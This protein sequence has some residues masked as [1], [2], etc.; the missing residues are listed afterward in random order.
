MAKKPGIFRRVFNW[1]ADADSA[2]SIGDWIWRSVLLLVPAVNTFWASTRSFQGPQLVWIFLFTVAGVLAVPALGVWLGV[3]IRHLRKPGTVSGDEQLIFPPS[4]EDHT[5]GANDSTDYN[6]LYGAVEDLTAE[7]DKLEEKVKT[8][9]TARDAAEQKAIAAEEKWRAAAVDHLKEIQAKLDREQSFENERLS[10][11]V[12]REVLHSRLDFHYIAPA[13]PNLDEV[14]FVAMRSRISELRE[15]AGLALESVENVVGEMTQIWREKGDW[16]AEYQLV[17]NIVDPTLEP[18][19]KAWKRLA[20]TL[21]A[22]GGDPREALV[23]F[24]V[25]YERVRKWLDMVCR[26][27]KRSVRNAFHYS[28][29]HHHDEALYKELKKALSNDFLKEVRLHLKDFEE[30][31]GRSPFPEPSESRSEVPT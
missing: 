3:G 1:G 8:L 9:T 18:A 10:W 22:A 15:T 6:K 20:A 23:L 14:R 28:A 24:C 11:K 16:T 7:N 13:V 12:E 4:G 26:I 27:Q 21:D 31:H 5:E 29:W 19:R 25:T 2:L 30:F 17:V